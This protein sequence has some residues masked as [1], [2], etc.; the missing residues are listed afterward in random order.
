MLDYT[1][2]I[3]QIND[4]DLF[5]LKIFL[6]IYQIDNQSFLFTFLVSWAYSIYSTLYNLATVLVIPEKHGS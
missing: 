6:F 2:N 1:N 3:D 5:G 4:I